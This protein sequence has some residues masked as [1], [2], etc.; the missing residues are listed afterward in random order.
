ML[1]L[2]AEQMEALR[3]VKLHAFADRLLVHAKH[4]FPSACRALGEDGTRAH[5]SHAIERA[6][7]YDLSTERD[8]CKYLNLT[9]SFGR[10]FDTDPGHAWMGA[11]LRERD[12]DPSHKLNRLY[13]TAVEMEKQRPV[14]GESGAKGL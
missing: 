12:S 9:F 7:V 3:A 1:K 11:I 13:K 5:I 14:A 8:L 6:R 2:R 10:D 4:Y